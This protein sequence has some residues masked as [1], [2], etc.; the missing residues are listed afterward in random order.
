[1]TT[2]PALQTVTIER[3]GHVLVMGLNRPDKRNAFDRTMLADLCRA[4]GLLER[5]ESLR[6]GVLVAHGEHFTAGLELLDVAPLIAAGES[7][8]PADGRDPWR[9]D[10]PWTKPVVAAVQGRCLTLGI[11]L[12]LAADIRVAAADARFAQIEVLRGIYPFGGASVRLPRDAG[13]GNAM[14]WL[15]TGDEFDAAE[16]HRIGLVQEVVEDAAAAHARGIEIAHTIADRAA[17][18]GVRATLA[19]AQLARSSG[20]AAAFDRLQPDVSRLFTT[21][22]AAEGVQSFVERRPAQFQGA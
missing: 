19:S 8:F 20:E 6:A 14:R 1:M 21:Q 5:D 7:P 4:Y 18:L 9:L 22:D 13:W 2:E 16:A 17:P 3:D 15:L 12:L 10:G 11:E